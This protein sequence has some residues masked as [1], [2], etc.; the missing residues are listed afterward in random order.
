VVVIPTYNE[1]QSILKMVDYL[2][3][4]TF[5]DIKGWQCHVLVVD[6]NSPDGTAKII[7]GALKK[8]PNLHLLKEKKKSGIGSAY[9]KGFRYAMTQLKADVVIE[10][11][12][13]FQHP[14]ATIPV[15]LKKI[16]QGFDYILGSRKI[17]GGSNPKGWGFKRLFF[18]EIGGLV[19]RLILFF[20]SFKFFRITDP[21]TGLKASRVKGFVDTLDMDNLYSRSFAYKLEF[22]F[23][24]IQLEA[25]VVEIPLK[26]GLRGAGESKITTNTPK[27]I[28][29]TAI[30]LRLS[31]P[32]T[33]RLVKFAIIG[34]VGFCVN[35]FGAMLFKGTI[36]SAIASIGLKNSLSNAL[37]AELAITSNFIGN[38][39]WTF[40]ARQI[41]SPLQ[42]IVKFL[43][44][45]LS[46]LFSGIVVPST[47][48]YIL[49]Y[50]FGDHLLIYQ[51]I[52]IFGFTIPFNWFIYNRVIWK[53]KPRAIK[54]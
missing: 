51:L 36:F 39:L 31:D 2:F 6:G 54:R 8:Y 5:P 21:T 3:D 32:N 52:A 19:A 41:T 27:D 10:M 35:I 14:P 42:I 53:K 26:F 9:V 11:D 45:N 28:L 38:N 44:F 22:L 50:A 16:D 7:T 13:D 12:G 24:M 40:A 33:R 46:S 34:G 29:R 23:R 48:I 47:F 15:M 43:T 17:K 25:R 37:A 49:S 18:S 30:L 1:S 4:K 20:P